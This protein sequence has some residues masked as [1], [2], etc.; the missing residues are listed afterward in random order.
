MSYIFRLHNTKASNLKGWESTQKLTKEDI[1]TIKDTVNKGMSSK[2]GSSIPTPFARMYLFE[3]AFQIVSNQQPVGN[4]MYHHLVSDCLDLYQ[5]VFMNAGSSDLTF[6]KWNKEERLNA[7]KNSSVEEHNK[8]GETLQLF[9]DSEKFKEVKE[10][11]LIYYKNKLVGGTSPITGFYVSPN[12]KRIMNENGWVFQTPIGDVLFDEVPYALH[13]R[14][15]DFQLYMY[16]Y[17]YAHNNIIAKKSEAFFNYFH[18]LKQTF[19][20]VEELLLKH[21]IDVDY[22]VEQFRADYDAIQVNPDSD[23]STEEL[24]SGTCAILKP[25]EDDIVAVIQSSDFVIAATRN[26]YEQQLDNQGVPIKINT[27]LALISGN[28]KHKY[29]ESIWDET[30]TVPD[31]SDIPL[32]KRKLPNLTYTYPYVTTGDFLE[33]TLIELPFVLNKESFFTGFSGDFKYLL[34]I[35]KDY[36]NYFSLEDLKKQL[37]IVQRDDKVK[38]TLKVPIRNNT[39]MEFRRTYDLNNESQV[40]KS[41]RTGFNIGIF[42][43]YKIEDKEDL[44]KYSVS[45]IKNLENLDLNFFKFDSIVKNEPLS[46]ELKIRTRA[47]FNLDFSSFYYDI[48]KQSFD[49]IEVSIG[50][51]VPTT[52]I[53]IPMFKSVSI[54]GNTTQ[55]N[56]AIDFGTSNTHI[57]YD[58]NRQKDSVKTFDI[59]IDDRQMVLLSSLE[60]SNNV[61]FQ[62]RI[63]D[64]AGNAAQSIDIYDR[65]YVPSFIGKDSNVQF[66]IR[67]SIC[68]HSTYEQG[69]PNLFSNI[70][71]GFGLEI[72]SGFEGDNEYYTNIKWMLSSKRIGKSK[73]RVESFFKEIL[74]LIKNKILLN[75]GSLQSEIIWMVPLS[76]NKTIKGMFKK[77]WENQA[78]EIFGNDHQIILKMKFESIVPYYSLKHLRRSADVVNIDI[79]GGTSD[80]LFLNNHKTKGYYYS[81]SFR[82]AGNDI[83][84]EGLAEGRKNKDNGFF[85]MMD[86]KIES[87]EINL[88][89][90]DNIKAVYDSFINNK[91]LDSADICS[92]LFKYDNY[93][94]FSDHIKNHQPL[95][96]ILMIHFSAILYH[97][98]QIIKTKD[99][100]IPQSISFTG[101]GSEYIKLLGETED[102]KDIVVPLL[103]KFTGKKAGPL[104]NVSLA[105][106]PKELTAQGAVN[107][108]H[109]NRD[110]NISEKVE[111]V[112]HLGFEKVNVENSETTVELNSD[113]DNSKKPPLNL[114]PL[115]D[116]EINQIAEITPYTKKHFDDFIEQLKDKQLTRLFKKEFE[117]KYKFD[118]L[119]VFQFI[120]NYSSASF[121]EMEMLAQDE[122]ETDDVIE[123]TM[124]FW[125]LKDVLYPLSKEL[126]KKN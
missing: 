78:K 3:A 67:T 74:W 19:S 59:G 109:F 92:F 120:K 40:L 5:F 41:Q 12:W 23:L 95:R 8:L 44:N 110:E 69:T 31:L 83:W 36:F 99:I 27:P 62:K 122:G 103:E 25:K 100:E 33:E 42:P 60:G 17:V 43:F 10:I 65:E 76:M 91:T 14:D 28:H 57:V 35:K 117:I 9:F 37:V 93:F 2:L 98:S 73:E 64:G 118:D 7:M 81:S 115:D 32:H 58:T 112:I 68:E 50:D 125:Y 15:I 70:N 20:N 96:T 108:K 80:I 6:K 97:I 102:I 77:I 13:Q 18:N 79:G 11:Y 30:I 55:F 34:P 124:F 86:D 47:T 61:S 39:Y 56:F 46:C 107:E 121:D 104:T 105:E 29:I 90:G 49:L 53:I 63:T 52:G 66:P 101:K 88:P 84:G 22:S 38:V 16:K 111:N 123:E 114:N 72:D 126:Y 48:S 45:L 71:I 26:H 94:K 82:F 85:L 87:G 21:Q 75:D 89:K 51:I 1:Q 106:N 113:S 54:A 119:D 24:Y 4:T 116:F